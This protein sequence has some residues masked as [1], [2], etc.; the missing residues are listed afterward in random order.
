MSLSSQNSSTDCR[1][2]MQLITRHPRQSWG[3]T[4]VIIVAR[5]HNMHRVDYW[6]YWFAYHYSFFWW[7]ESQNAIEYWNFDFVLRC[8][9][10]LWFALAWL[11]KFACSWLLQTN[12]RSRNAD[13]SFGH[14]LWFLLALLYHRALLH[15][16][17][18]PIVPL[19]LANLSHT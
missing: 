17:H 19:Y 7:Q 14:I 4:T 3:V 16:R 1:V 2:T 13:T 5:A 12:A 11:G 10:W 18:Q 15:Q 6:I 8:V 9:A